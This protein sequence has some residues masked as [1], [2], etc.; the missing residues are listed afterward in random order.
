[1]NK[2]IILNNTYVNYDIILWCYLCHTIC[3][4]SSQYGWTTMAVHWWTVEI[5]PNKS[6]D[7]LSKRKK[8]LLV[9]TLT[10]Q[11]ENRFR[12][13]SRVG[14]IVTF[15]WPH[16]T[17]SYALLLPEL[18]SGSVIYV[19]HYIIMFRYMRK[20]RRCFLRPESVWFAVQMY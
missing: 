8:N 20:P 5:S 18:C 4:G 2:I 11:T 10:T 7:K 17:V 13:L 19:N 1:M 3:V 6:L 12:R 14:I 15:Y 9:K 16:L